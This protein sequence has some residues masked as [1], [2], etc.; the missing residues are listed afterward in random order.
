MTRSTNFA[1]ASTLVWFSASVFSACGAA[2]SII[3][4][5]ETPGTSSSA[6][7]T[8]DVTVRASERRKKYLE[9]ALQEV[10]TILNDP[11]FKEQLST[12]ADR[13]LATSADKSCEITRPLEVLESFQRIPH[14]FQIQTR[15]S[16]FHL[17]SIAGTSVCGPIAINTGF[18]DLW[19]ENDNKSRADVIN[20]LA[21]ELIHVIPDKGDQ[22]AHKPG[23]SYTDAG[24]EKCADGSACSDAFLVSYTWGDFVECSYR[25]KKGEKTDFRSCVMGTVNSASMHR[26]SMTFKPPKNAPPACSSLPTWK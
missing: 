21:H 15:K 10:T 6:V 5:P 13:P 26:D 20:N 22:C 25:I 7:M 14:K 17:L 1:I 11:G 2:P 9:E 3:H 19:G 23:Q 16:I 4:A 12:F 24:H 18:I 8:S